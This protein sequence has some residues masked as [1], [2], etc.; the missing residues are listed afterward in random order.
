MGLFRNI[1]RRREEIRKHRPDR[2]HRFVDRLLRPQFHVAILV[3]VGFVIL[4]SLILMM[5]P[6]VVGWRVGQHAPH[7]IVARVDFAY[8]DTQQLDN[9]RHLSRLREPRVYKQTDDPFA[10]LGEELSLLPDLLQKLRVEQLTAPYRKLLD[11]ATLT[12]IQEYAE[13]DKRVAWKAAVDGY[14]AGAQ[15]LRLR[16]LPDRERSED[17]G[18]SIRLPEIGGIR[19]DETL[20]PSMREQLVTRLSKPAKDNFASFLFPTIVDVTVEKITPN[21][22]LDD[23]QTAEA[24]NQAADRVP[25]S[26]GDVVVKKNMIFVNAGEIDQ[27]ELQQLRAEH[28]AYFSHLGSRVWLQRL[29]LIGAVII[30]AAVGSVYVANYQPRIARNPAR[31]IGLASLMVSMLLLSQLAGLGTERNYLLFALAPTIVVSMILAIAY[32]QRFAFGIGMLHAV[33]ATLATGENLEFLLISLT[34]VAACCFLLEDVRTRSKLLEVGGGPALAMMGATFAVGWL[35]MNPLEYVL[36]NAIFAGAAGLAVGFLVLGILPFIERTFRITTSM[37]L[38]ELADASHPLLRRLALEAPGTYSHSL[39]VATLSEEAAEAIGG[40]SLLCRVASYYHDVGKI[41]KA[42]YFVENQQSGHNR[43]FNLSPSVSLLIIIGHV[44]DGIELAKEYS[45]PTSVI[46]FIQ[47]HHGTTLVEFFYHRARTG[48]D[49]TDPLVQE[50]QEHQYRYPGPKPRTRETAIVMLADA[51]ESAT[52]AMDEP[53]ASR[54]E[55]L[56]HDMAMKR[57]LDGQFDESALTMRDLELI[58]R[59]LVKSLLG[60]YHGRI[61]YPDDKAL[62]HTQPATTLLPGPS[63]KTA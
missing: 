40:N 4:S 23:V 32:D 34:G 61:Q 46:P 25:D 35:G 56:V 60:L 58:E 52:R 2:Q 3:A 18:R 15:Q 21:Y 36:Q 7:D 55:T 31:A 10:A 20:A 29:G 24:R 42:D 51:C 43:H 30:V 27:S 6:S 49:Q 38:L 12:K 13:R 26:A 44:K 14:I 37:T 50:V 47:Q 11:P 33:L 1:G 9:Q 53:N 54:I 39:Q 45:L 62:T 63:A 28:E 5:R 48:V 16:V 8:R 41:N 17:L 59:S 57:L 19:A 22:A